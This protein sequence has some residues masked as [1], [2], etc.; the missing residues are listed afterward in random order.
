MRHMIANGLTQLEQ[1]DSVTVCVKNQED[2][3]SYYVE[4]TR[5]THS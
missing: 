1:Q 2:H 3:V 5:E 4:D